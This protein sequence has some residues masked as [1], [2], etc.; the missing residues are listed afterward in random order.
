MEREYFRKTSWIL[1]V[2]LYKLILNV[3]FVSQKEFLS[4]KEIFFPER[5]FETF[6]LVNLIFR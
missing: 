2:L 1:V 5:I 6:V 4:W 3:S